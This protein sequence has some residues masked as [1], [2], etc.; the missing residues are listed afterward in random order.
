MFTFN[1]GPSPLK[2]TSRV[3]KQKSRV[4]HCL[5][6]IKIELSF[7]LKIITTWARKMVPFRTEFHFYRCKQNALFDVVGVFVSSRAVPADVVGADTSP[8]QAG[9][10]CQPRDEL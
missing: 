9:P 5:A 8:S 1:V 6:D 7:L 3:L 4:P 10:S 2:F